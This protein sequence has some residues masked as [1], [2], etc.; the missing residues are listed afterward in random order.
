MNRVDFVSSLLNMLKFGIFP[1]RRFKKSA[2]L[3]A[4]LI[5]LFCSLAQLIVKDQDA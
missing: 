4:S 1:E 3:V 2:I 5:H